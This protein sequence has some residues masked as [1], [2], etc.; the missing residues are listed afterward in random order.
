MSRLAFSIAMQLL[1]RLPVPGGRTEVAPAVY[2]AQQ[3]QALA[4]FPWVG[5]MIGALL[6]ALAWSVTA[7][8][9][10]ADLSAALVLVAWVGLTGGLHLDGLADSADAW[11]GGFGDREKTLAIMKDPNCGPAGVIALVLVLLLKW[12]VLTHLIAAQQ[13]I[14][15]LWI[16]LLVRAWI[17]GFL[18]TTPYVRAA[19]MGAGLLV[20]PPRAWVWGQWLGLCVL[21]GLAVGVVGLGLLLAGGVIYGI[22]RQLLMARLGGTT[23]DTTGAMIEALETLG[24]LLWVVF[25]VG[26]G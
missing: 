2:A 9:L 21:L 11:L 23:G 7:M 5:A 22:L 17:P 14:G 15:L 18:L 19:G 6:A 8:G 1:T 12:V 3:S 25:G 4:Y 26:V 20:N 24:L 16:A 13:F 10:V